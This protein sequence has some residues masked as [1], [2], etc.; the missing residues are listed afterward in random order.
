VTLSKLETRVLDRIG[1]KNYDNYF[2]HSFKM[3]FFLV[4]PF[5]FCVQ[6]NNIYFYN[7]RYLVYDMNH[8]MKNI[9]CRKMH[10]YATNQ[11]IDQSGFG[12]F[13]M[14]FLETLSPFFRDSQLFFLSIIL[15]YGQIIYAA[16]IGLKFILF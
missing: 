15:V 13:G 6:K 5:G 11:S 4:V 7:H 2:Y 12:N 8:D 3:I 9:C 16:N 1:S 10:D 14:R